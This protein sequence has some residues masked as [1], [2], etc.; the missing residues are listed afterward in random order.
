MIKR[1]LVN[2]VPPCV[3]I[4][5]S[6]FVRGYESL[7]EGDDFELHALTETDIV[8]MDAPLG[9]ENNCADPMLLTDP[10]NLDAT[11]DAC[12]DAMAPA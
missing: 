1:D 6:L 3:T 8:L 9:A 2:R 10:V 5:R 12:S 7:K 11:G 4:P